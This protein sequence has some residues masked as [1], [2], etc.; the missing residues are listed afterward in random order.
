MEGLLNAFTGSHLKFNNFIAIIIQ[1]TMLYTQ[2]RSQIAEMTPSGQDIINEFKQNLRIS[3][4]MAPQFRPPTYVL[5]NNQS[6]NS[7]KKS[8]QKDA[9]TSFSKR[10]LTPTFSQA[11]LQE[12]YSNE[13]ELSLL[14]ENN[15]LKDHNNFLVAQI[16]IL[17]KREKTYK[18]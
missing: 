7:I 4:P 12:D 18:K 11:T 16:K 15:N 14:G 17:F 8:S 3:A 2:R 6:T 10:D 9:K 1:R 5:K 13:I